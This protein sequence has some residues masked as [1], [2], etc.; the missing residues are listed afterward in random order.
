MKRSRPPSALGES[1]TSLVTS[2]LTPKLATF[3]KYDVDVDT[4]VAAPQECAEAILAVLE[5]RSGDG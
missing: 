3:R 2:P 5:A 1:L 4:S